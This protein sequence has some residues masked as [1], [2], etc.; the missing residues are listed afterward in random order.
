MSTSY[1]LIRTAL[2]GIILALTVEEASKQL[3]P[4]MSDQIPRS[5][6]LF[7]GSQDWTIVDLSG[8]GEELKARSQRMACLPFDTTSSTVVQRMIENTHVLREGL[9]SLDLPLRLLS[10]VSEIDRPILSA[11]LPHGTRMA[12]C[13]NYCI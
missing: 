4:S 7:S 3:L 9:P 12:W 1:D 8:R 6:L 11:N 13:C 5:S 2:L 10:G